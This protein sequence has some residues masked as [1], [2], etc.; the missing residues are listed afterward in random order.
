[1]KQLRSILIASALLAASLLFS[2]SSSLSTSTAEEGAAVYIVFV[3]E[4][5]GEE[6]EAFHIRTLAAVL[7][8]FDFVSRCSEESARRAI[9]FHYT[10][11]ASGFAAKLT[12]KQ[13]NLVS[14]KLCQ[15]GPTASMNPLVV[16]RSNQNLPCCRI[17][18]HEFQPETKSLH[19][20]L[21]FDKRKAKYQGA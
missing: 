10:H 8:R 2:S 4:P 16:L 13:S 9:L 1:M 18:N 20:Y 14:F 11:A 7:G 12:P 5:V 6:P 17:S 19:S 3:D 21:E 15:V